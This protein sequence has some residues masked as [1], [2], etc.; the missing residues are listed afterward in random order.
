[1]S[2]HENRAHRTYVSMEQQLTDM[3]LGLYFVFMYKWRGV[4]PLVKNKSPIRR[5]RGGIG[6]GS[7][8]MRGA[9]VLHDNGVGMHYQWAPPRSRPT[10]VKYNPTPLNSSYPTERPDPQCS[11]Q[12]APPAVGSETSSYRSECWNGRLRISGKPGRVDGGGYN[13]HTDV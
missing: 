13:H 3:I 8:G 7:E 9:Y 6:A 11:R 5:E 4:S 1:M 12:A 2:P 10:A